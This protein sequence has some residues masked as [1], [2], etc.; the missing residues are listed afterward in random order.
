MKEMV[1]V[2]LHCHSMFSDGELTPEAL[3][4]K[5]ATGGV[6]Y[7]SLTDHD[8]ID[9]LAQ[10]HEALKRHNIGFLTGVE[11]TAHYQGR[12][13]HLLGYGFDAEHQELKATLLA[14]RHE[15]LSRVQGPLRKLPSQLPPK[16]EGEP[17]P[18]V[19][20]TGKLLLEEAIG[21]VHRAGGRAFLAHPFVF[22]PNPAGLDALLADLKAKGL[23]G[24]EAICGLF[25]EQQQ[26]ALVKL[27]QDHGLLVSAGSDF[28]DMSGPSKA[29]CWVDM[30]IETWKLL[31][32][33]ISSAPVPAAS[34]NAHPDASPAKKLIDE[35]SPPPWSFVRVR[36]ILP[37]LFAIALFVA[38]IWGLLLPSVE[39]ILID[40]KRE[41]I[42]ELTNTAMSLLTEA[43][44]EERAGQ[45]TRRQAQETAKARIRAL[46]YGK[47]GKDYFWLQD[48]HPRMLMHPYRPDLNGQDV[49]GFL[50]PR[51]ARIFVE[52][53]QLVQKQQ[54]GYVEYV[55]QWKD[56]PA[57]LA[58]KESYVSGFAPWGWI[59]GTG[60]YIDDVKQEI[61]RIEQSLVYALLAI[62]GLVFLL[63]LYIIRQSLHIERKRADTQASL[64]EAKERYRS[65]IEA[66]TEGTLLVLDGRCRYANPTMLQ[67][68][69]YS[70]ERLELLELSDLL[71]RD[72]GNEAV[73]A[74]LE[75][76]AGGSVGPG[77]F[78][79]MLE[80]ADGEKRECLITLNPIVFAGQPGIIL[81]AKEV[82][83]SR[84]GDSA[85]RLGKAAQSAAIG[86]FQA[87]ASRRG[88]FIELNEAAKTL[89]QSISPTSGEQ[90]G[91]ADLFA[92]PMEYD[93]FLQLLRRE[94]R[95]EDRILQRETGDASARALALS[96]ELVRDEQGEPLYIHGTI[97]DIT[98]AVK[99]D[100]EREA[101]ILKLQSSLL[102]LHE[103]IGQS[104][105]PV[106]TCNLETPIHKAAALMIARNATGI[107]VEA[108]AGIP[109]GFVTDQ[110]YRE[111][112][113]GNN[114]ADLQAPVRTIMS[115]PL[116]T[117]SEHALIYEALMR[118]EEKK[119]Q[120]L[121]VEDENGR[122]VR[123]VRAKELMQFHRYG[124]TVL[125][126]EIAKAKTTEEVA[127]Y[128][129]RVPALVKALL[130]AGARPRN[131]TYMISS[132]CDA[133]TE[134]FIRFAV[135]ELGPP[136]IPFAFIA[137]GSQGRQE[138]TLLTD[139]DNAIIFEQQED[140]GAQAAASEYFLALGARVCEWL[141]Q[142][143]YPLCTGKVMASNP[144]WCRSLPEWKEY[145]KDWILKAEPQELL[146][147]S[148][149]FDFRSVYGASE[150]ARELRGFIHGILHD[151]P[152]FLSYFAQNA[153]LFK[154]P[155]R[156]L[157]RIIKRGGLAEEAG[158]LN[159]KEMLMPLVGFG[160]LYAL[161]NKITH[162]HT[163]ERIEAL[164]GK[165]ALEQHACDALVA[166]Y[167]FLMRLRFQNQLSA[168]QTGRKPDNNILLDKLGQMDEAML[169]Q[170]FWQIESAQKKIIYDFLGGAEWPGN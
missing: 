33:S 70:A 108:A 62:A 60:I 131:V 145:F 68:T 48:M 151:R 161:R 113:A 51:G 133:A 111:R 117:I 139:Q 147:F 146:E 29:L 105:N 47:E 42:R 73:L 158:L 93:E 27:A 152:N 8:S 137:L 46:R 44:L 64:Q 21:L 132:V 85:L 166:S 4:E 118:M 26:E 128:C 6:R 115:A 130:D 65:L 39:D 87:K 89:V 112:V 149:F 20:D 144:K 163:M 74:H 90:P 52:F 123:I 28:H 23:D 55:W 153:L 164:V 22:E 106:V 53:A 3:A 135:E 13:I 34:I 102:F 148:I 98:H 58:A 107:L 136:P 75:Q 30:P 43:E 25:S 18:G 168:I 72:Q 45:L 134:R 143:G 15:R 119:V 49:S 86:L 101:L 97:K 122:I 12:E 121:A 125:P 91:V 156:L 116:I 157:G 100:A 66:T 76:L 17:A 9:G 84:S 78:E 35:A 154:P 37:S 36:V 129:E 7:A 69:G 54:Q 19:A 140:P 142:A 103:P 96:A 2:N 40:R 71:P 50:D 127:R 99:R 56:D 120:H 24:I 67:M 31:V 57:R 1:R 95:V 124:P 165:N 126:R 79:A 14:L 88:V 169:K 92:D 138:Q 104:G 38:A 94:G 83:P 141:D 155:T 5:L 170:A 162:T 82:M 80:R 59:I 150:F 77:S 61:K 41:M 32:R 159:L 167:D 114:Q 110:D 81:L 109:V 16:L 11:L 10:F 160:R 63:L